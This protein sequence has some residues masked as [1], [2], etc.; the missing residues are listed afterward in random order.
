MNLNTVVLKFFDTILIIY[1][2]RFLKW[3]FLTSYL[4][5]LEYNQGGNS[6][7]KKYAIHI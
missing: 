7:F 6:Y 4:I 5:L 3:K 1:L 2:R